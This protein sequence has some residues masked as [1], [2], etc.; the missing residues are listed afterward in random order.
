VPEHGIPT[1]AIGSTSVRACTMNEAVCEVMALAERDELALVVTPNVDHVVLLESDP[2]FSTSYQRAALRVADGAPLV[3]LARM[4][5]TPIPERV[6]GV[7]LT[8]A[9][10]AE[11][12]RTQR[13]VYFLGGDPAVL[14]AAVARL[15]Q[16]FPGLEVCG[17]SAP[18]VDLETPTADEEAALE[19]IR[20]TEPDL[21]F[22]FLGT[23]K[24]EKWFWRRASRLPATVGLAVGGTVDMLAG[25]RRRAPRW[26]QQIGMEWLWRLVQD[27]KRLAHRYLVQDRAFVGIAFRQLRERRREARCSPD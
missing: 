9:V 15:E 2:E 19:E 12:E 10:I 21:L 18:R 4:L 23:P 6:A 26:V 7:D 20:R 24:Q 11:A 25:S 1:V 8:V 27:P 16:Q 17:R 14:E 5:H 3:L 13:S 22:L